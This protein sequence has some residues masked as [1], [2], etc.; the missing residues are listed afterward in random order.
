[1]RLSRLTT[2][3]ARSPWRSCTSGSRSRP[4]ARG[5]SDILWGLTTLTP[6]SRKNPRALR[7]MALACSYSIASVAYAQ[8]PPGLDKGHRILLEKG[9][10]IHAMAVDQPEVPNWSAFDAGGWNG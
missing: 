10:A 4:Q 9:F 2:S 5:R 1:M 6:R 3:A 8:I 7:A